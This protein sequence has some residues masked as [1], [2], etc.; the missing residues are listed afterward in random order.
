[1]PRFSSQSVLGYPGLTEPPRVLVHLL[2]YTP[3]A[4]RAGPTG[5]VSSICLL[6]LGLPEEPV[7]RVVSARRGQCGLWAAEARRAVS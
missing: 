1:M 6:F 7:Q 5:Q 2:M 4:K 3:M